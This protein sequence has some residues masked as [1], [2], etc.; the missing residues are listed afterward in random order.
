MFR[1]HKTHIPK[2][3]ISTSIPIYFSMQLKTVQ[4]KSITPDLKQRKQ[5]KNIIISSVIFLFLLASIVCTYS[6]NNK[7]S[8]TVYNPL[9]YQHHHQHSN[10]KSSTASSQT[11]PDLLGSSSSLAK[12]IN[13]D[14]SRAAKSTFTIYTF[15]NEDRISQ[16]SKEEQKFHKT[17]LKY[18]ITWYQHMG[19]QIQLLNYQDAVDNPM[20]VAMKTAGQLMNEKG[21][22]IEKNLRLLAWE[23][24]IAKEQGEGGV[25]IDY[26]LFLD[27]RHLEELRSLKRNEL[28]KFVTYDGSSRIL[29]TNRGSL[30][31]LISTYLTNSEGVH[32]II[33]ADSS[34]I[35]PSWFLDYSYPAISMLINTENPRFL[36]NFIPKL[37]NH[38]LRHIKLST[39]KEFQIVDLV[40]IADHHF[41]QP[42]VRSVNSLIRS[43]PLSENAFF[44]KVPLPT[45]DNLNKFIDFKANRGNQNY[46]KLPAKVTMDDPFNRIKSNNEYLL[47]IY[48][49]LFPKFKMPSPQIRIVN[50]LPS[51]DDKNKEE[52]KGVVNLVSW[53]HSLNVLTVLDHTNIEVLDG[54]GIVEFPLR[55]H[56]T[57]QVNID[58]NNNNKKQ[59]LKNLISKND[60]T[61]FYNFETNLQNLETRDAARLLNQQL[62]ISF[63]IFDLDLSPY[64]TEQQQQEKELIHGN[65]LIDS[66]STI[67]ESL[68]LTPELTPLQILFKLQQIQKNYFQY[69][70]VNQR[71]FKINP[72]QSP[73]SLNQLRAKLRSDPYSKSAIIID[74]E[75]LSKLF[76]QNE[77][78]EAKRDP[79]IEIAENFNSEDTE[80]WYFI[81]NLKFLD[82]RKY[83]LIE[84]I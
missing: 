63:G 44:S 46:N 78:F 58:N 25:F 3:T 59:Q 72:R 55:D 50:K 8:Y 70:E 83:T 75:Q 64:N 30:V 9:T 57:S 36:Y 38:Q 67:Y 76:S 42:L 35:S 12:L 65:R 82:Q 1:E 17:L 31:N 5:R 43:S 16:K 39:I 56:I 48:E 23:A 19:F 47:K 11:D 53:P 33:H 29:S 27:L 66:S 81:K 60:Q 18:W 40:S 84:S 6:S 7:K 68:H 51:L 62:S 26:S 77:M 15:F 69:K 54:E 52:Q 49:Q 4:M 37:I 74:T 73:E 14:V 21:Q 2:H 41:V 22:I 79:L 45:Y 71:P 20:F 28:Q 34:S 80:I 13:N 32:D 10:K 24:N 61:F